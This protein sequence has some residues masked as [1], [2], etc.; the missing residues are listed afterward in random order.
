[1]LSHEE[2]VRQKEKRKK[3]LLIGVCVIAGIFLLLGIALIILEAVRNHLDEQERT[4]IRQRTAQRYVFATPDYDFNIFEDDRYLALDRNVW[5]NDGNMRTVI[6]E[7]NKTTY[8]PQLQFMY[9]VIYYIKNG[10][11]IEYN[12]IFDEDF[13]PNADEEVRR[14]FERE[15]FTMQQLFEIELEY[16][17]INDTGSL[18][19]TDIRL[20]YRIRNNNGTFRNDLDINDGARAVVYMLVTDRQ[21]EITAEKLLTQ[22]QYSSRRF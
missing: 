13:F 11:Y 12:K 17:E 2:L 7:G 15:R 14:L 6:D 3:I 16:M 21:G 20:T 5:F 9:D 22:E 18:L 1:M 4:V 8:A 19:Y 10:D